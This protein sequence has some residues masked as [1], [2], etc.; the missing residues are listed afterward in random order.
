[1]APLIFLSCIFLFDGR[2]DDQGPTVA[3]AGKALM[4]GYHRPLTNMEG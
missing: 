4:E 2:D 1:M 3:T